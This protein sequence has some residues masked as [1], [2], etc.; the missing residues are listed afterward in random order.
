[1]EIIPNLIPPL[2]MRG[3]Q[4]FTVAHYFPPGSKLRCV[5]GIQKLLNTE[6]GI[7]ASKSVVEV[8]RL[9]KRKSMSLRLS[10]EMNV[11]EGR[12]MT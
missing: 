2:T 11:T 9:V 12:I 4:K 8:G 3:A 5:P 10:H 1:M 7:A 6:L